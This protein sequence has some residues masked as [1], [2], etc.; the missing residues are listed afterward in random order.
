LEQ[1]QRIDS[2]LK[3][4]EENHDKI[5]G[6]NTKVI[7]LQGRIS[8]KLKS[9]DSLK[10]QV[11]ELKIENSDQSQMNTTLSSKNQKLTDFKN[12][13]AQENMELKETISLKGQN[14]QLPTKARQ[15][16]EMNN[17]IQNSSI[18]NFNIRLK[19]FKTRDQTASRSDFDVNK[20]KS[21]LL[22]RKNSLIQENLN[23]AEK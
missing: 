5:N 13:F 22:Q 12:S 9:I 1:K 23:Y 6:L 20:Q 21:K 2:L 17:F 10:T 7:K 14:I 18:S 4:K 15:T 16:L 3:D 19:N 11:E 8:E